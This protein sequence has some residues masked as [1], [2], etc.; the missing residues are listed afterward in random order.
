MSLISGANVLGAS[1]WLAGKIYRPIM[2]VIHV[3]N[4][5][6][7]TTEES[8]AVVFPNV[9]HVLKFYPSKEFSVLEN[10][11]RYTRLSLFPM[12]SNALAK[13]YVLKYFTYFSYI[14]YTL[15]MTEKKNMQNKVK[16]GNLY[17]KYLLFKNFYT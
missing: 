2:C 15:P 17:R 8:P 5:V 1:D 4:S 3:L 11:K 7:S 14:F 12:E 13:S 9:L 10:E 16:F 6:G